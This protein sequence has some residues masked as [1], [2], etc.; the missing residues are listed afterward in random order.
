MAHA[1]SDRPPNVHGLSTDWK[2]GAWAGVIAGLAFVMIEMLGVM[3]LQG[4]SPW[5]PPRM[6]AAMALGPGI[7]EGPAAFNFKYL[8]TAMMIHIPMSVAYGL[9]LAWAVHRMQIVA[10]LAVGLAFGIAIYLVNF[11]PIADAL[12]PWFAKARGMLSVVAHAMF[13]IIAAG[14]YVGLRRTP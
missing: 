8:M 2:A 12:F 4:E 11:Y 5:G 3:L 13:G 7:L 10:A 1:S 9:F 6:I 14:T